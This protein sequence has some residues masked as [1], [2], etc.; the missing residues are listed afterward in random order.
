M[1]DLTWTTSSFFFDSK[2][3]IVHSDH[4]W[5]YLLD[6]FF[7]KVLN[8]T[9]ILFWK[10]NFASFL[11]C[12]WEW[13]SD[14]L[15]R[16][17]KI[18][19]DRETGQAAAI[20]ICLDPAWFSV[21]F[22]PNR[23]IVYFKIFHKTNWLHDKPQSQLQKAKIPWKK[24]KTS[25][26]H[27]CVTVPVPLSSL[28]GGFSKRNTFKPTEKHHHDNPKPQTPTTRLKESRF[29]FDQFRAEFLQGPRVRFRVFGGTLRCCFGW[30][31]FFGLGQQDVWGVVFSR[32]R[33][34]WI[35]QKSPIWCTV[36]FRFLTLTKIPGNLWDVRGSSF[37]GGTW[38]YQGKNLPQCCIG[39][40]TS[41]G[42]NNGQSFFGGAQVLGKWPLFLK[43]GAPQIRPKFQSKQGSF[44][45]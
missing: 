27:E 44:G 18:S 43:V 6:D 17:G 3:Q 26:N 25:T 41:H 14:W 10:K 8:W 12:A 5:I 42:S 4:G 37:L 30:T 19:F 1:V 23:T 39:P 35:L 31:Y 21:I 34:G 9:S 22:K 36:L 7:F 38:T 15:G 16:S 33:L 24:E 29:T 20:E 32:L 40:K 28:V 45:F 2:R 11:L 13:G